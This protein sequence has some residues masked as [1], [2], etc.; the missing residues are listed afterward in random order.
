M[1]KF[2]RSG[3]I[4]EGS[5]PQESERS[6]GHYTIKSPQLWSLNR[7]L[8]LAFQAGDGLPPGAWGQPS[9]KACGKPREKTR[10]AMDAVA[11]IQPA[12]LTLEKQVCRIQT[13][14]PWG[15]Q[16]PGSS[17]E[18]SSRFS[19][20]SA[21]LRPTCGRIPKRGAARGLTPESR[22]R[23]QAV[24]VRLLRSFEKIRVCALRAESCS[25]EAEA[26]HLR[27]SKSLPYRGSGT[28][29]VLGRVAGVPDIRG[30]VSLR[31]QMKRSPVVGKDSVVI[32]Q[33][34]S[35]QRAPGCCCIPRSP[36][37]DQTEEQVFTHGIQQ[38]SAPTCAR[39][40][41]C[42]GYSTGSASGKDTR[43]P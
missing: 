26:V 30:P 20:S 16:K 14:S 10:K 18:E 33:G 5:S 17:L 43:K 24:A 25:A 40:Q 36:G 13:D 42:L 34:L 19:L 27:A 12:V 4:S 32:S 35:G 28:S 38:E 2:R 41:P 6:S 1:E 11:V 15:T 9:G 23:S 7:S 39:G 3:S 37:Y 21:D 8:T 29:T 31:A 22:R